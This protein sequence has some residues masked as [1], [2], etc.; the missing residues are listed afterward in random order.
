MKTLVR[1]IRIAGAFFV[2]G[3]VVRIAPCVG[4]IRTMGMGLFGPD[5]DA[6]WIL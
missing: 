5:D 2:C 4:A 3:E 6:L 1:K